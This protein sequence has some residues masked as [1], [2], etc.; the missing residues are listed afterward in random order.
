MQKKLHPDL[1]STKSKT[2]QNYS[3]A[4]SSLINNA[5][6]TLLQPHLR[7][8]YMLYRL[9]HDFEEKVDFGLTPEF[10]SE[11]LEI[12]EVVNNDEISQEELQ[13]LKNDILEDM[14]EL[15]IELDELFSLNN[16]KEAVKATSKLSY[17][18]RILT[19]IHEKL[20]VK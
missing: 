18:N 17:F 1:F 12:M 15:E 19:M 14:K 3:D 4:Q 9:G 5:Y 8:K 20:D 16:I 2:E 13:F 10:L 7:A 6:Q 11:M